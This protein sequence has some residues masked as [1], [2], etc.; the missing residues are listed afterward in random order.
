M[1]LANG[2]LTVLTST[3][4]GDSGINCPE[5]Y[6]SPLLTDQPGATSGDDQ[7]IEEELGNVL[8]EILPSDG[9]T[10]GNQAARKRLSGWVDWEIDGVA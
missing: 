4:V 7:E 1:G 5:P 2:G 8:L 9:S 3:A 6:H 10:I